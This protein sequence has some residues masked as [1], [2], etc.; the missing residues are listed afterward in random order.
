MTHNETAE[1]VLLFSCCLTHE[2]YKLFIMNE[3]YIEKS[4]HQEHRLKQTSSNLLKKKTK[5]KDSMYKICN[6][7]WKLKI[8]LL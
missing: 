8:T 3:I 2:Y 5:K 7:N 6:L 4:E 1:N